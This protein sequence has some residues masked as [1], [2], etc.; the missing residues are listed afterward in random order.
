MAMENL[1]LAVLPRTPAST[2]VRYS[3]TVGIVLSAA[4]LRMALDETLKNYPLLLFVPA[5]F[6]AALLFD[7]GSGFLATVLSAG[8]AAWIFI[9]PEWSL[10]IGADQWFA[11]VL[12]VVIG[13]G[14]TMI[15][16]A[17]R[18]AVTKLD[19][20]EKARAV[21][22]EELGHRTKNDLATVASLLRLQA[23]TLEEGPARAA[24]DASVSRL[25]VI[26]QVHRHLQQSQDD[27]ASVDIA[28]YLDELT[29]GLADLLRDVR[30]IALR[31]RCPHILLPTNQASSIGLIVNELVTNAFKYAFP[32]DQGGNV[33]ITLVVEADAILLTV[34][35]NGAG[36]PPDLGE[37]VGSKLVKLMAAQFDGEVNRRPSDRGCRVD[38]RLRSTAPAA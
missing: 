2:F 10:N 11:V 36:C 14:I 27:A 35:D 38:V 29:V 16:E 3:R 5:V 9:P 6:L 26:A 19:R 8:L 32:D 34:E 7:R 28:N 21:Q 18:R 24:L 30:P 4:L 31:V 17:L 15:T 1:L 37:G 13:F 20:L 25:N 23:R 33:E 22:L 12:F